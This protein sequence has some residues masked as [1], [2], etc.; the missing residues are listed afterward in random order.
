[1]FL[2]DL[3]AAVE[4]RAINP[5]LVTAGSNKEDKMKNAKYVISV[6]RK[7]R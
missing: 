6:A 2:L 4:P 7:V 3:L 1:V 5:K